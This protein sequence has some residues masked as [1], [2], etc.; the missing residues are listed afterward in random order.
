M[1]DPKDAGRNILRHAGPCKWPYTM[2]CPKHHNLGLYGL[3]WLSWGTRVQCNLSCCF[4]ILGWNRLQST[5][6]LPSHYIAFPS[7]RFYKEHL[8]LHPTK[9]FQEAV[10]CFKNF[11]RNPLPAMEPLE[12]INKFTQVQHRSLF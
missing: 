9:S 2:K 12:L 8:Q 6:T 5:I 10:L 3:E 4:K 7:F 11:Y 1:N